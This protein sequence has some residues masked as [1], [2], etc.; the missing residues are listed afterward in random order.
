MVKKTNKSVL[1]SLSKMAVRHIELEPT[2]R[3]YLLE[4][5]LKLPKVS[6]LLSLN[7][8]K[9]NSSLVAKSITSNSN[10]TSRYEKPNSLINRL[11]KKNILP[12]IFL[13][14]VKQQVLTIIIAI[15][16]NY[17]IV[18]ERRYNCSYFLFMF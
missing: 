17:G 11:K 3:Q 1:E 16:L 10:W 18:E 15:K 13:L 9:S 6:R 7:K 8:V 2:I 5:E 4:K 12:E 14:A